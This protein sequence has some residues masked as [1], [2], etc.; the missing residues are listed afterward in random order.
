M[1]QRMNSTAYKMFKTNKFLKKCFT[2]RSGN[3]LYTKVMV[4]KNLIAMTMF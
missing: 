4:I 1:N 2:Y 3:S